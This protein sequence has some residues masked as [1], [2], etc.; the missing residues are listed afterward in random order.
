MIVKTKGGDIYAAALQMFVRDTPQQ[1]EAAGKQ[2]IEVNG[3]G[4]YAGPSQID[5]IFGKG[6][7]NPETGSVNIRSTG[8]NKQT[9]WIAKMNLKK[10]DLIRVYGPVKKATWTSKDGQERCNLEIT[11]E[12]VE[13][14]HRKGGNATEVAT[15]TP[16]AQI[17]PSETPAPVQENNQ[18]AEAPDL[19]L[20]FESDELPF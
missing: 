13:I 12:R 14:D 8:W 11:I 3:Y 5:Y 4:F 6:T 2:I 15:A 1:K 16:T 9:E 7:L 20:D 10:G 17:A 18:P 19:G